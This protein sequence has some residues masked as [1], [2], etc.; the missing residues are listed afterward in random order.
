MNQA[1]G[2]FISQERGFVFNFQGFS[3][4]HLWNKDLLKD[5]RS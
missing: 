5:L 2:V 4:R 1:F 3:K